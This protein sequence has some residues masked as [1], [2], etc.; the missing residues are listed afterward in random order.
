M[1]SM[2]S[3]PSSVYSSAKLYKFS[4]DTINSAYQGYRIAWRPNDKWNEKT[5]FNAAQSKEQDPMQKIQSVNRSVNRKGSIYYV[6][7]PY[8]D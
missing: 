6:S 1:V 4:D 7:G 3:D 2:G 5:Y 8:D